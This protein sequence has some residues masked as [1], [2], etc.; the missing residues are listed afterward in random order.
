MLGKRV[1]LPTSDQQQQK[2]QYIS[3]ATHGAFL[4]PVNKKGMVQWLRVSARSLSL[5]IRELLNNEDGNINEN[6]A[7]QWIK[8]HY[9]M[10]D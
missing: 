10:A 9:Y 4:Q 2:Q 8:L 7:K 3:S 5:A 6:V 1:E